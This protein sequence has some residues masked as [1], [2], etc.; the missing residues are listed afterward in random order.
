MSTERYLTSTTST[1][2]ELDFTKKHI[3]LLSG[4]KVAY[5][6]D[7]T[8]EPSERERKVPLVAVGHTHPRGTP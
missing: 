2:S 4:Q 6:A 7:F 1:T 8:C 3:A 5:P